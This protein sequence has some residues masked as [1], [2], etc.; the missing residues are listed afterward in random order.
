MSAASFG[1]LLPFA[2]VFLGQRLNMSGTEVG[3][4]FLYTSGLR[5]A[6][7]GYSGEK[8][9][10]AGR[11]NL[12][13]AAL[14]GRSFFLFLLAAFNIYLYNEYILIILLTAVYIFTSVFQPTAQAAVADC[15]SDEDFTDAFALV[16][17][18]GN[19][20]WVIGPIAGGYLA[21]KSFSLLFG[22]SALFSFAGFIVFLLF[23]SNA[24]QKMSGTKDRVHYREVFSNT[25]FVL[26]CAVS[27]LMMITTS[28]L[29]STLPHFFSKE[30]SIPLHMLGYYFGIN[31]FTVILLQIPAA[32]F[33]HR[34]SP[35][36]GLAIGSF[37]YGAGYFTVGLAETPVYFAGVITLVSAAEVIVLPLTQ[38]GIAR[39]AERI[40]IGRYMGFFNVISIFAWSVGPLTAMEILR[41][42]GN[43][44]LT[45]WAWISSFAFTASLGFIILHFYG[46]KRKHLI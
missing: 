20:G 21:E 40:T 44:Y 32:E 34:I 28:Q 11:K 27:F 23:Y 36:F 1:S 2:A 25:Q 33:I 18:G 8:S 45:A 42:S 46:M 31:G 15:T 9:D 43:N 39:L 29:L 38:S 37:L 10:I 22:F 24:S 5:A 35:Y 30:R 16:R 41:I 26:Y 14:F 6:V 12:M 19:F 7:Q 4:F 3:L 17:I 13:T